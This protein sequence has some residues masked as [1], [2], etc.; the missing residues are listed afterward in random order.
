MCSICKCLLGVVISQHLESHRLPPQPVPSSYWCPSRLYGIT[1]YVLSI[2]WNK[3]LSGLYVVMM[4]L[5]PLLRHLIKA[6]AVTSDLLL[7]WL[8][9]WIKT[10]T[11]PMMNVY[12]VPAEVLLWPPWDDTK[13]RGQ[14]SKAF[15]KWTLAATSY[16][17]WTP[18]ETQRDNTE[19]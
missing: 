3:G 14:T 9:H 19:L 18:R 15:S 4:K 7:G 16:C 1:G 12:W 17:R 11:A 5:L 13:Q 2:V 10:M 8:R 6:S